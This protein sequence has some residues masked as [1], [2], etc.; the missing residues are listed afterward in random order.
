MADERGL[1]S[2]CDADNGFALLHSLLDEIKLHTL[3]KNKSVQE[4]VNDGRIVQNTRWSTALWDRLSGRTQSFCCFTSGKLHAILPHQSLKSWYF[5]NDFTLYAVKLMNQFHFFSFLYL[6][7]SPFSCPTS[8]KVISFHPVLR[9]V[10]S[11]KLS[12]NVK[13]TF[14][15]PFPSCFAPVVAFIKRMIDPEIGAGAVDVYAPM[16]A[17]QFI[18]FLIILFSWSAFSSPE[19]RYLV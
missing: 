15:L 4:I 5:Q 19:V 13:I 18:I 12:L 2:R 7:T 3:C 17:C 6:S 9:V 16:F 8:L 14:L 1:R 10:I 11:A